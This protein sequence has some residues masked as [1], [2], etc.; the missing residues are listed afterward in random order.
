MKLFF[1]LFASITFLTVSAQKP[2]NANIE[3]ALRSTWDREIT[4]NAPGQEVT[5]HTIKIGTGAI[6][7]P[8]DRID[9][10]P[11]TALVTLAKIDFTVREYFTDKTQVTHRLMTAKVFKDQFGEW[12]VMSN[13][14]KVLSTTFE[15]KRQEIAAHL[16][17]ADY[18]DY[19]G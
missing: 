10:I 18:T 14:M 4:D 11:P 19:A 8:Q 17:L 2:T 3:K 12:A 15:K 16:S 6:A 5:I 13:G 1:L 7:S 9:G